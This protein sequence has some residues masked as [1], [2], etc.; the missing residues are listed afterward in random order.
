VATALE[1]EIETT[2]PFAPGDRLTL[3]NV[4]G[5]IEI[6][7]WERNEIEIHAV[8]RTRAALSSSAREALD[9]VTVDIRPDAAGVRVDTRHE[10]SSSG[11]LSWLFGGGNSVSVSY[12]IRLPRSAD[13]QIDTVN[14]GIDI[15]HVDGLHDLSSTNGRITL[16]GGSGSVRASTTNGRI[17]VELVHMA[18]AEAPMRLHTTNGGIRVALPSDVSAEL[19]ART[20]NGSI[21][22]DFPIRVEGRWS[23]RSLEGSLNGG[24][25]RIELRTTNGSIHVTE[26]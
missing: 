10:R 11:M 25:Q 3:D 19:S 14:G 12:E 6:S 17:D 26:I 7:T 8:K 5:G 15:R 1:E 21:T 13:L 22:T 4:N 2:L 24:G 23:R 16:V 18:P 9:R 20:T